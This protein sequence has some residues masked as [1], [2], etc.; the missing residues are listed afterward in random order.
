MTYVVESQKNLEQTGK[1]FEQAIANKQFSILGIHDLKEKLNNKG[2]VFN[3]ECRIYEVCNPQKAQKVVEA[4]LTISTALPC[5]VSM[6][7][8]GDTVKLAT[9]KP[10]A[11]LE[12]F[13][14]PGLV[15]VAR[16]VEDVIVAAMKEAAG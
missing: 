11:L 1:A 14:Q 3:P 8:D 10:T 4:D 7:T 9:I 12:M 6:Y 5:R 2:V 16:D 15:Q 13:D